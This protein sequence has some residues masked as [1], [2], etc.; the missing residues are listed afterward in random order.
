MVEGNLGEGVGQRK[1]RWNVIR[2]DM[3]VCL[4]NE[5]MVVDKDGRRGKIRIAD[6]GDKDEDEKRRRNNL[7]LYVFQLRLFQTRRRK[8]NALYCCVRVLIK[9]F[10]LYISNFAACKCIA[11]D[12][13]F[14]F[15]QRSKI[16]EKKHR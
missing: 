5:D 10:E 7:F 11:C 3:R 6:P 14:L 15:L 12:L 16:N 9:N 8:F 4:V 2:N 13:T 1:S